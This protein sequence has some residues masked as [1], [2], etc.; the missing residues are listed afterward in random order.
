MVCSQHLGKTLYIDY[1]LFFQGLAVLEDLWLGVCSLNFENCL[2]GCELEKEKLGE[3]SSLSFV[4]L[5]FRNVGLGV[6]S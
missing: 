1:L 5:K 3:H 6:Y 4:I 2:A